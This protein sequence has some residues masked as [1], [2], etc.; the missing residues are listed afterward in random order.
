MKTLI[1]YY[2]RTGTNEKMAKIMHD[3]I[4]GDLEKIISKTNYGGILGWLKGGKE[5]MKKDKCEIEPVKFN[6][7]D[8]ELTVIIAPLWAGV[9]P[10]PARTYIVQNRENFKEVAFISV[11]GSG[12]GNK[13]AL[14][15]FETQ[16]NKKTAFSLILKAKEIKDGSY[17]EKLRKVLNYY[18]KL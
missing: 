5:A 11:S 13:N 6:P 8:Y 12:D 16:I 18:F 17:E 2:S 4:G 3:K 15:D 7:K 1:T 10:P 9:V 14:T